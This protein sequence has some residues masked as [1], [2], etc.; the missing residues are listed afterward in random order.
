MTLS[1]MEDARLKPLLNSMSLLSE[2]NQY[3]AVVLEAR[4]L[5]ERATQI[6]QVTAFGEIWGIDTNRL[7]TDDNQIL[8]GETYICRALGEYLTFARDYLSLT[9]PVTMVI[10]MTGVEGYLFRPMIKDQRRAMYFQGSSFP[11]SKP[12]LI[13]RTQIGDLDADPSLILR[14]YFDQVWDCSGLDR[15]NCFPEEY[16]QGH[17]RLVGVGRIGES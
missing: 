7:V 4:Q 10:G 8:A 13:W 12:Y 14:P 1:V 11:F 2:I 5:G 16:A 9:S 15:R 17:A 6:T 3:G